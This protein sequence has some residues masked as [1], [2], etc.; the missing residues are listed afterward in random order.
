MDKLQSREMS[1][2]VNAKNE[3]QKKAASNPTAENVRA[4]GYVNKAIEDLVRLLQKDEDGFKVFENI[5]AVKNYLDGEGWQ[6]SQSALYKHRREGKLVPGSDGKFHQKAVD[7]YA[8]TWLK[9]KATG[10][11][12]ATEQEELQTGK[13]RKEMDKLDVGIARERLKL[14]AEQGKYIPRSE[15]EIDLAARAGVLDAGLNHWIRTNAADWIALAG[16]D[17]N[18]VGEVITAM[19]AGKDDLINQ[20]ASMRDFVVEFG[21]EDDEEDGEG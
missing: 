8:R 7:K 6:I 14:E 4:L 12:V 2:L 9:V 15:V 1:V 19:L 18:K 16:G 21:G 5:L 11:T 17:T 13:L 20:Y 10:K 3:A